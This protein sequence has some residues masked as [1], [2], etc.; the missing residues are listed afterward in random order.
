MKN[1]AQQ[2]LSG[3]L[4]PPRIKYDPG[5][6]PFFLDPIEEGSPSFIRHH[7]TYKGEKGLSI[8]GSLYHNANVVTMDGGPCI[9]YLHGLWSS[10]MEAQFLV[11]NVCK[12]KIFVFC[13]DMI[14]CGCSSGD[15]V[16]LTDEEVSITEELIT[17]L[18]TSFKLG[19]FIIWGRG[20]GGSVGLCLKHKEIVGRIADSG[21]ASG[22]EMVKY[23]RKKVGFK[24]ED[25]FDEALCYY[26]KEKLKAGN[27]LEPVEVLKDLETDCPIIFRHSED[28]EIIP[29]SHS[30]KL[31]QEC[32]SSMKYLMT[33][34]GSHDKEREEEW[35]ILAFS[36]VLERFN[37]FQKVTK[38]IKMEDIKYGYKFKTFIDLLDFNSNVIDVDDIL[39]D[40]KVSQ[41]KTK[42]IKNRVVNKKRKRYK[43]R[44]VKR[45][46]EETQ[47]YNL[48]SI[49]PLKLSYKTP[50]HS[51]NKHHKLK[52]TKEIVSYNNG[53]FSGTMFSFDLS[54]N[55]LNFNMTD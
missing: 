7:I 12:Y 2:I 21:F 4:R 11:P 31:Y 40:Y 16:L 1:R 38:I 39:K 42:K 53:I 48:Y 46:D 29:I 19:P 13:F 3:L 23:V 6:L 37:K 20:F 49:P 24:K 28:D 51:L 30:R 52:S 10:Q 41:E 55:D 45:V 34:T 26:L 25:K 36:F 32:I 18:K 5:S 47:T 9:I 27:L 14:G 17:F 54:S 8:L 50:Y 33:F 15:N 43:R 22:K 44:K 35:L